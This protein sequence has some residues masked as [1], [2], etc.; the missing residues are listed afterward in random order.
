MRVRNV[1]ALLCIVALMPLVA[2][3]Q[4]RRRGQGFER[5]A[6]GAGAD[7]VSARFEA[8]APDIG[9]PM[10]SLTVYDRDGKPLRLREL[11][12]GHYTVIVLGCLT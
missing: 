8:S 9:E 5:G 3:A 10:P 1:L 2:T 12:Q 4:Q 11:L 6:A 7:A